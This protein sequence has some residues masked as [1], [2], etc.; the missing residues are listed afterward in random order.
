MRLFHLFKASPEPQ[1]L[2]LVRD[3]YEARK[4]PLLQTLLR[5]KERGFD[6]RFSSFQALHHQVLRLGKH[7]QCLHSM[8]QA[9]TICPEVF[10][11]KV[12]TLPFPKAAKSPLLQSKQSVHQIVKDLLAEEDVSAFDTAV[13]MVN[14]SISEASTPYT[15]MENLL[16]N[17]KRTTIHAEIALL[18]SL[19]LR[20]KGST[21]FLNNDRYIACSKA[22]CYCCMLYVEPLDQQGQVELCGVHN[23]LYIGWRPPTASSGS[24]TEVKQTYPTILQRMV[25]HLQSALRDKMYHHTVMYAHSDSSTGVTVPLINDN[26]GVLSGRSKNLT[27]EADVVSVRSNQPSQHAKA[28]TVL[29]EDCPSKLG[30][31]D[32]EEAGTSDHVCSNCGKTASTRCGSCKVVRY[33]SKACQSAQHH[34]H[35]HLCK[36][37]QEFQHSPHEGRVRAIHFP[38]ISSKPP[39]VWVRITQR[40]DEEDC[41]SYTLPRSKNI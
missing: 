31:F 34:F 11:V 35:R 8:L 5:T 19:V 6:P 22:A 37:Y 41:F 16:H 15:Y 9:W 32:R 27:R 3:C 10:N 17:T 25:K 30:S 28:A 36:S 20:G 12:R 40:V 18:D 14:F 4:S 21:G 1:H 33:C 38:E 13:R 23:N 29:N 2:Q 24:D 26:A 39:W 7:L